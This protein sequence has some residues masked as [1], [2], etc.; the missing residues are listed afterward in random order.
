MVKADLWVVRQAAADRR[1]SLRSAFIRYDPQLSGQI[2]PFLVQQIITSNKVD[3]NRDLI[4][5]FKKN[6]RF[7][8]IEFCDCLEKELA[9]YMSREGYSLGAAAGI[10]DSPRKRPSTVPAG[11]VSPR[12]LPALLR[13]SENVSPRVGVG[14]PPSFGSSF[15]QIR[16][17]PSPSH[18]PRELQDVRMQR[19]RNLSESVTGHLTSSK[20]S[21]KASMYPWLLARAAKEISVTPY[22]EAQ[23]GDSPRLTAALG[24]VRGPPRPRPQS[25]QSSRRMMNGLDLLNASGEAG[26][27]PASAQGGS[28]TAY[29][30]AM[31]RKKE[32]LARNKTAKQLE[33][34]IAGHFSNMLLA[35]KYCDV[36]GNGRLNRAEMRRAMDLWNI[37][38]NEAEL[39]QL[40]TVGDDNGDGEIDYK[41]FV[42]HLARD[43]VAPSAMGKRGDAGGD[44]EMMKQLLGHGKIENTKM[45]TFEELKSRFQGHSRDETLK[46]LEQEGKAKEAKETKNLVVNK[47][48]EHFS[49]MR[50]AFH[51]VD[52]D[53]SGTV[54]AKEIR[55]AMHMWG[56]DLSD[57]QLELVMAE[58]DT[59]GDG[60]I[61][62]DEFIDHLA[63][64]TVATAAM[65]KRG[66]QSKDAMGEDAYALLNEQLGHKKIKNYKMP[67]MQM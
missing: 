62:Y 6:G 46:M 5:T 47:V 39:E 1:S 10:G 67:T 52:V 18:S 59:D 23:P 38:I 16:P 7:Y 61:K 60:Q 64:D 2:A 8:W 26:D 35:F 11:A 29:A 14:L 50:K 44:D 40:F 32:A 41:E 33:E 49:N 65:G 51:Y 13:T 30:A 22:P 34:K 57:E 9:T 4:D 56:I 58:C 66:M 53:N 55:R 31:A 15:G 43:T 28:D 45:P 48:A 20:H 36:D 63:R 3:V 27:A 25:M 24:R 54:D 17:S 37:Q 19:I 21:E 42:D 12:R